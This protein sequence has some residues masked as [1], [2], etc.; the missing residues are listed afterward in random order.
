MPAYNERAGIVA[1]VRSLVAND[2]RDIEVIVVDDASTDGTA[3]LVDS[4]GLDGVRV[5]RKPNGGKASA[6]N[7]GLLY[8]SH[9]IIVTVDADTVFEPDAIRR[10]IEPFNDG[11]GDQVVSPPRR[12]PCGGFTPAW[13]DM[14]H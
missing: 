14:F 7:T 5:I 6:L 11:Y 4:L 1:T 13:R 3:N 8:A 12:P 9:E 10:L 2:H